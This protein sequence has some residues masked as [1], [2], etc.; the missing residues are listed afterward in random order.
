MLWAHGDPVADGTT[1]YLLHRVFVSIFQIQVTVFF[2]AFEDTLSL[3][4]SGHPMA[5]RMHQPRQFLLIRCVGALKPCLAVFVFSVNTIQEQHVEMQRFVQVGNYSSY[6]RCVPSEK[7]SNGKSKGKGNTKNGNR[8]LAMAF[9]EAAHYA[10]IWEPTIKRYLSAQVQEG[11]GDGGQENGR[12][13]AH[14]CVL[15]HV[16]KRH[17][18]LMWRA[19]LGNTVSGDEIERGMA[20]SPVL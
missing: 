18:R 10:S 5:D 1:Q 14:P 16:E 11:T 17:W 9:V 12:Q 19:P 3:Q 20:N 15:S 8:Y 2:I 13:Q 7:I 6:A 4:I